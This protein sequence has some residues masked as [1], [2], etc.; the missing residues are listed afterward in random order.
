[1]LESHSHHHTRRALFGVP[2]IIMRNAAIVVPVISKTIPGATNRD[3]DVTRLP[4]FRCLV[5]QDARQ[6][7]I[8]DIDCRWHPRSIDFVV[9]RITRTRSIHSMLIGAVCGVSAIRRI[10]FTGLGIAHAEPRC[11]H[12]NQVSLVGAGKL[13]DTEDEQQQYRQNQRKLGDRLAFSPFGWLV[14]TLGVG[15]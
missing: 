10:I 15:T 3:M 11:V 5:F 13:D 9:F 8:G 1:M 2:G 4:L 12:N 6:D 14:V 7:S